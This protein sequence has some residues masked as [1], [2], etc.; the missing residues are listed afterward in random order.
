VLPEPEPVVAAVPEP[1]FEAVTEPVF[2]AATETVFESAPEPVTESATESV[3][4]A[5]PPEPALAEF[6]LP[7][8]PE[9]VV[10][11]LEAQPEPE[12]V[13]EAAEAPVVTFEP[14]VFAPANE[15]PLGIAAA[16]VLDEEEIS[17]DVDSF[18]VALADSDSASRTSGEPSRFS[19]TIV[20]GFGDAWSDF[21]V[22][23]IAAVAADLGV[24]EHAPLDPYAA[25]P[26]KAAPAPS[27]AAGGP[28]AAPA[29]DQEAL[30][31]IGDA[32]RQVGLDALVIEEFERGYQARRVKKTKKKAHAGAS[33]VTPA[34]ERPAAK[35]TPRPVQDEWGMFD[36]EQCGFA[37]LEDEEENRPTTG[38][39]VRVI[40]Y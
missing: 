23:T 19:F 1:V 8:E 17:L 38:T 3:F 35:P 24:G 39:R 16:P 7:P 31:L 11:E 37:A 18:Q 12:Q 32:A 30:S 36:P 40:S 20:D 34:A 28:L 29:L 22:P 21:E 5:P 27:E 10:A 33:P 2:E 6:V 25:A 15:E 4:V 13:I 14:V 9:P 26:R